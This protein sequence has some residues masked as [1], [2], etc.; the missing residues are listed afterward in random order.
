MD[1]TISIIISSIFTMDVTLGARPQRRFNGDKSDKSSCRRLM[2][3]RRSLQALA[4]SVDLWIFCRRQLI[5]NLPT[6]APKGRPYKFK[7]AV[8]F[9]DS[10]PSGI[11]PGDGAAGRDGRRRH[12]H[13]GQGPD[14][15]PKFYS[16]VLCVEGEAWIVVFIL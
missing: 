14:C 15:I 4:S 12:E 1:V 9:G 2:A 16:R 11:L 7:S 10:V 13:G 6:G 8:F 5:I 3:E